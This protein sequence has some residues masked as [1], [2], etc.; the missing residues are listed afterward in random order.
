VQLKLQQRMVKKHIFNWKQNN[1]SRDQAFT[2]L[3]ELIDQQNNP[4]EEVA[5]AEDSN[6]S[7]TE[8]KEVNTSED[9]QKNK[10]ESNS[11]SSEGES[12]KSLGWS[13]FD[14]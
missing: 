8:Q 13:R 14:D 10:N 6:I 11:S 9:I 12:K 3:L 7:T 2:K 1:V 4:L 5:V